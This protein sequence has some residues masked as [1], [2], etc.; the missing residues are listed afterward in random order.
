MATLQH[1]LRDICR[2]LPAVSPLAAMLLVTRPSRLRNYLADCLRTYRQYA[3]K[4]MP[5][6]T[7]WE[8]LEFDGL[9]DRSRQFGG[10]I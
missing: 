7:P 1:K 2:G 9:V 10:L 4:R 8:L 5:G 6:I 3:G